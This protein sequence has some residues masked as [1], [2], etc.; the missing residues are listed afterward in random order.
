MVFAQNTKRR[1][2][3][4]IRWIF[5]ERHL[6]DILMV[7]GFDDDEKTEI[8]NKQRDNAKIFNGLKLFT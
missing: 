7:D 8:G 5:F 4:K 2:E 3:I 6:M 1:I